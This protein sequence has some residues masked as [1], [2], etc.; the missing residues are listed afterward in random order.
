MKKYVKIKIF[1]GNVMPL[2]NDNIFKFNA[3]I[4]YAA[5]ESL[6]KKVDGFADNP[7]NSPTTKIDE[8][9]PCGC[10]MLI[11]QAFDHIENKHTLYR[12]NKNV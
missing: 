5:S 3:Y 10:P 12:G 7:E 11:I 6:I 1:L 8:D 9:I 4:I 2:E